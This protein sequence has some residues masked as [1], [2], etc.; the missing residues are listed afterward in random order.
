LKLDT[1]I[2]TAGIAAAAAGYSAYLTYRNSKKANDISARKVSIEEFDAQQKRY[3]DL[4]DD[5]Q[6]LLDRM[7]E[8]V[9]RLGRMLHDEQSVS[10]SLRQQVRELGEA[11]Q[12]LQTQHSALLRELGRDPNLGGSP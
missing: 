12:R 3:R 9:D 7:Q 6:K 8:Q 5:Q 4:L 11:F 2:L 1:G 10:D